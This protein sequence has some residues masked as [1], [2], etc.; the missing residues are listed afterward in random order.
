MWAYTNSG[1]EGDSRWW[2][3]SFA[4]E[5]L[6]HE[7]KNHVPVYFHDS[8]MRAVRS[9]Q[10]LAHEHGVTFETT[11]AQ[12]SNGDAAVEVLGDPVLL[13]VMVENVV[14][15]ALRCSLS[16]SRV[17]LDL[18]VLP[19]SLVLYVRDHGSRPATARR[20][21]FGSVEASSPEPRSSGSS[22]DL[23]R[24]VAEH[25]HGTVSLNVSRGGCKFCIQLPRWRPEAP[26]TRPLA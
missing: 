20:T 19:E 21:G 16:G 17:V 26:P 5:Q 1:C 15:I 13:E 8:I 6:G 22:L 9:S 7:A 18:Q 11:L 14:G 10:R 24:R 12:S 3:S 25:H 23:A 4:F 2:L